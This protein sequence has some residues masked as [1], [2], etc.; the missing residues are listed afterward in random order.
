MPENAGRAE[1][2]ETRQ[3][4]PEKL[5]G[6][7]SDFWDNFL[8]QFIGATK[9]ESALLLGLRVAGGAWQP[10]GDLALPRALAS[11]DGAGKHR[12]KWESLA[13]GAVIDGAVIKRFPMGAG[14]VQIVASLLPVAGGQS[15]LA[16]RLGECRGRCSRRGRAPHPRG[17]RGSARL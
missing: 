7:P 5:N 13:S 1:F 4:S 10:T 12:A 8:G 16:L 11:V 9:A 17:S 6:T 14:T 2:T 3:G 15:V